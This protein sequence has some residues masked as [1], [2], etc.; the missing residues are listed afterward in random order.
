[1]FSL[2]LPV[3]T[4]MFLQCV[5]VL[6]NFIGFLDL[7]ARIAQYARLSAPGV[8]FGPLLILSVVESESH[9]QKTSNS[10]EIQYF[11]L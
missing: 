2:L 6:M 4:Y 7:L 3:K 8:T 1:M 9:I 10:L 11:S 5:F